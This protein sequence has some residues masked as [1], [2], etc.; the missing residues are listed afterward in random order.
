MSELRILL[1]D[2]HAIMR[3]G[4]RRLINDEPGLMVAGEASDGDQLLALAA[5]CPAD[6]VLMDLVMPGPGPIETLRRLNRHHPDLRVLVLTMHREPALAARILRAGAAGFICKDSAYAM[7]GMAL[8]KIHAGGR[9]I[10]PDLVAGVLEASAVSDSGAAH[11]RLSEREFEIL[12]RITTGQ[13]LR[14]IAD[15]LSISPKTVSTHKTRLMEKLG[16]S[17]GADLLNYAVSNGL[18]SPKAATGRPAAAAPEWPVLL[19]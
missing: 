9:F 3:E 13:A 7:V 8:R 2:D 10:D 14:S 16:V 15:Q 6:L 17:N 18:V 12:Q 1:A 4:L 19:S 11:H 5:Q